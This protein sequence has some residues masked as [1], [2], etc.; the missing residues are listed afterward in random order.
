MIALEYSLIIEVTK[1]PVLQGFSE[2]GHS[3]EDCI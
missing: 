2:V 3:V 1:E